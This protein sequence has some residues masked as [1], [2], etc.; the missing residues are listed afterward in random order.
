M[1]FELYME[2]DEHRSRGRRVFPLSA[3]KKPLI[4]AY[5]GQDPFSEGEM[6]RQPWEDAHYIGLALHHDEIGLDTDIKKG[7]Q[8]YTHRRILEDAYG[9]LPLTPSQKTPSG[10]QHELF[11]WH[12]SG[13]L[14]NQ[15]QLPDGS[16]SDIDVVSSEHRYF[17]L[18]ESPG[19]LSNEIEVAELP[20]S[21]YTAV[22]KSSSFDDS[23]VSGRGGLLTYARVNQ[24]LEEVQTADTNR[25]DTLT[26]NLFT[27]VVHGYGSE[28][29]IEAF[30]AAALES[31]LS[32]REVTSTINSVLQAAETSWAPSARWLSAVVPWVEGNCGRRQDDVKDAAYQFAIMRAFKKPSNGDTYIGMSQ[33]DLAERLGVGASTARGYISTLVDGGF[34]QVADSP[35]NYDPEFGSFAARFR[36]SFP[37][38]MPSSSSPS[39]PSLPSMGLDEFGESLGRRLLLRSHPMFQRLGE[40]QVRE[41]YEMKGSLSRHC[42]PVL[43]AMEDRGLLTIAD[44]AAASGLPASTVRRCV[45]DLQECGVVLKRGK[46]YVLGSSDIVGALDEHAEYLGVLNR[47]EWLRERHEGE[48]YAHEQR[49]E[50]L[51]KAR[52]HGTWKRAGELRRDEFGTPF[53]TKTGEL[54]GFS[55]AD[56]PV[57]AT[58]IT[59]GD[60]HESSGSS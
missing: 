5:H 57:S 19:V 43:F 50:S 41:R 45:T 24:L 60:A 59:G 30:R 22:L 27:A 56:R 11:T 58:S 28:R 48:R 17:T 34:L 13:A 32:D 25:N 54:V 55:I 51:T 12:G 40:R 31:G 33:R 38:R 20:E 46:H 29:V 7:K 2:A 53:N 49:W 37:L 42:I 8:G 39:V 52:K 26:R 3:E 18:H 14:N 47:P 21:W 9:A 44:L 15:W 16:Y 4:K 6:E 10:G 35:S 36:L 1:T 23:D